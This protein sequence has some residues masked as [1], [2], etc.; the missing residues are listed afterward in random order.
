M[1]VGIIT[2]EK[3]INYGTSLQ[4]VALMKVLR[5]EGS[6]AA[7]ISHRCEEIDK[8]SRVFDWKLARS[9]SYTLAHLYN[10][11]VA[12]KRKKQFERFWDMHYVIGSNDPTQY[13]AVV[14]GSDQ[15]WNYNLTARDWFYF[16]DFPKGKLKK[17]SYAGSFGLSKIDPTVIPSIRPLLEDFDYLSVREETAA[18]LVQDICGRKVQLVL[19]PTLLL[20]REQWHEMADPE[21]THKGYIFVYTVF[22][23]DALWDYAYELSRKTGLPIRTISYSKIHRRKALYTFDA[24]PAQWISHMMNAD[25][26]V[27]NSFHGFAFSVNFEKQFYYE[28]PPQKSGVSSRLSDMAQR[29]GLLERELGLRSNAPIDYASVRERLQNDREDSMAFIRSFL[30][31]S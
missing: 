6:D 29:Y 24:G 25:Y 26:V 13:D 17:V 18:T 3:A 9:L 4:A 14:A 12:L 19:D 8:T 21:F 5:R 7:F 11:D 23:S 20:N 2:F 27:T 16:L 15:V 10:L 31:E 22:N 30:K 28:L 1:K